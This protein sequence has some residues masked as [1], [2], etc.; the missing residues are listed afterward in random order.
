M[1]VPVFNFLHMSYDFYENKFF[2]CCEYIARKWN[3]N[4]LNYYI[5]DSFCDDLF[6]RILMLD[7]EFYRLK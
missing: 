1:E 7:F 2:L 6:Q 5:S 4:L 3:F